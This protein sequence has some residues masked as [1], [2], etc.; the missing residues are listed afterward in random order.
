MAAAA[1]AAVSGGVGLKFLFIVSA[2]SFTVNMAEDCR[3]VFYGMHVD[4]T[5]AIK[6]SI[7]NSLE[8][9]RSDL[10]KFMASMDSIFLETTKWDKILDNISEIHSEWRELSLLT[11]H[12]HEKNEYVAHKLLCSSMPRLT[13]GLL[14]QPSHSYLSA[15]SSANV[16]SSYTSIEQLLVHLGRDWG[17]LG[18]EAR[19]DTYTNGILAALSENMHH[20]STDTRLSSDNDDASVLQVLVPG[21]GMGR[22]AMELAAAGGFK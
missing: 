22:L 5:K 19:R 21:A 3:Y 1:V 12:L 7:D 17:D 10:G 20:L 9:Y 2:L 13:F 15:E 4:D 6:S 14:N 11:P 16:L 18:E 8:I